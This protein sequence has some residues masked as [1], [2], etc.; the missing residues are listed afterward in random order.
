M[1]IKWE[2]QERE[3]MCLE[4]VNLLKVKRKEWVG[5][6]WK[7]ILGEWK[8]WESLYVKKKK[9]VK[10][11]DS[12]SESEAS[13]SWK[14]VLK[15]GESNKRWRE[16][17]TDRQKDRDWQKEERKR[18]TQRNRVRERERPKRGERERNKIL[19]AEEGGTT[20][21]HNTGSFLNFTNSS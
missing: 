11:V 1:E 8:G 16:C 5:R 14:R 20:R 3:N 7:W 21:I 15:F 2:E 9:G 13:E 6:G 18:H 4:K 12:Y 10:K 17:K 19:E